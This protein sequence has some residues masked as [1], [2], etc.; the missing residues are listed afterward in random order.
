[1]S[2]LDAL[3]APALL[4]LHAA[5]SRELRRRGI[6]RSANAP[7][8][9]LAEALFCRAFGWT[10]AQK[11]EAG[12]DAVDGAGRPVQIKAHRLT[13]ENGS[14]QLG[15]IRNLPAKAFDT[16]AAVLFDEDYRVV[17]AALIPHER[18]VEKATYVKHT[19]SW[20]FLFR[21][22]VISLAGVDDVTLKLQQAEKEWAA[23]LVGPPSLT[24]CG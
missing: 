14:R 10:M 1:M 4:A 19:N 7:T 8:G 9:D 12:A 2:D 3:D 24:P 23:S 6:T 11:S 15:Q 18:V 21:D 17:K 13:V 5:V 16:L 22:S 20:R